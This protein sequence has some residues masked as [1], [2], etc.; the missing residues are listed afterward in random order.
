M[1]S[2]SIEEFDGFISSEMD[3]VDPAIV[4]NNKYDNLPLEGCVTLNNYDDDAVEFHVYKT[5]VAP[6]MIDD[7]NCFANT[8]NTIDKPMNFDF[9]VALKNGFKEIGSSPELSTVC[10]D[11]PK[12]LLYKTIASVGAHE[13]RCPLKVNI[14]QEE[15]VQT[16]IPPTPPFCL[17]ST[18]FQTEKTLCEVTEV[19]GKILKSVDAVVHHRDS[20]VGCGKAIYPPVCD[21]QKADQKPALEYAF[22]EKDCSVSIK[23]ASCIA[24]LRW[25]SAFM[26]CFYVY[27]GN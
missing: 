21:K 23:L 17:M 10:V 25:S 2:L 8:L 9:P 7:D 18:H 27:S 24:F 22:H 5:M 11:S 4:F 19:V 6:C 14:Q 20:L 1:D 16:Q 15:Q 12:K 26:D 13:S 3:E